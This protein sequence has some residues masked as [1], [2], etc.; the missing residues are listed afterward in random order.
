MCRFY[1]GELLLYAILDLTH[2]D[3]RF[4]LEASRA[5]KV[6]LAMEIRYRY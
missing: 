4:F 5:G 1:S 6:R 3:D 2:L